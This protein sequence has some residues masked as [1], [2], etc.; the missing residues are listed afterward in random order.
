MPKLKLRNVSVQGILVWSVL[1]GIVCIAWLLNSRSEASSAFFMGYSTTRLALMAVV[2][3]PTLGLAAISIGAWQSPNR[4]CIL[5]KG[6]ESISST[7]LYWWL[8]FGGVPLLITCIF[9]F[10]LPVQRAVDLFGSTALYFEQSKPLFLYSVLIL[11]TWIPLAS[12]ARFGTDLN[13]LRGER[14][15]IRIALIVF[16]ALG[17]LSGLIAIT[18]IGFGFDATVWNAPG[19]PILITQVL[20]CL[21]SALVVLTVVFFFVPKKSPSVELWLAALVWVAAS[22]LWL[23][24]P[25]SPTYY[26]SPPV[27]P[28]NQSYPLSDAFN[29][30][31]IA[32]NVLIGEGF[33]SGGQFAIRRPLYILFLAALERS[34]GPDY[35]AIVNVQVVVLA[36]FPVALFLLGSKLHTRLSGLLV[37]GFVIF[38]EA[39]AITLGHVI[40]VSHAKL[41]MADL[42]AA[43]MMAGVALAVFIWLRGSANNSATSL[44]AGGVLGASILLRSQSL[45]LL[46]FLVVLPILVWKWRAAWRPILLF[47]LG[48]LIVAGPWI[49]RNRALTGQWIIEDGINVSGFMANRYSLTPGTSR[50]PLLPG[51]SEGEYYA[52]QMVSVRE[53][54]WE[55]PDYVASFVIDNFVRNEMLNFMSMPVSWQLRDLETHVRELPYWPSWEGGLEV[56]SY[57]PVA[58][59]LVLVSLGIAVAWGRHRWTGMMPLIINIGFTF[60]LALARVSGWR[61]NL[62]I[63]WTV[64]FYFAIGLAQVLI[65]GIALVQL[66]PGARGFLAFLKPTPINDPS[67]NPNQK[68][69]FPILAIAILVVLGSALLVIDISSKPKYTDMAQPEIA[70][71][72][73]VA[74]VQNP[75][76]EDEKER[77]LAMLSQGEIT[78]L[79][80]RALHPRYYSS[81]QGIPERNFALVDPMNF[82]KVTF[83][84]IGP[85]PTS[86][87]LPIESASFVFPASSDVLVFKCPGDTLEAAAVL[88]DPMGN[89]PS[90]LFSSRLDQEC[91]G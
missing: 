72:L 50:L 59:N 40:N 35:Q 31:V 88:I 29:H 14:E 36:L 54:I 7:K 25:A 12:Q 23:A 6:F 38:R 9:F 42:P 67:S 51:E 37:A 22:L 58:I 71:L 83:Y 55:Y 4:Y 48:T 20:L 52:R 28:N 62:P 77:L 5:S 8:L 75:S 53:F 87:I 61:Y 80:G 68:H 73:S 30:D 90:V 15:K 43:L 34:I 74:E 76:T 56:E 60:S 44:L 49:L 41:L 79:S 82:N 81:G 86:V 18:G 45:L 19:A 27:P 64:L 84:L 13:W 16:V 46:P 33:R 65:W 66:A 3:I 2:V 69:Q 57:A 63:D 10:L 1:A 24:Q 17:I 11:G 32:N 78:G 26:N 47:L 85:H 70:N 21:F 39:N 91:N 89:S